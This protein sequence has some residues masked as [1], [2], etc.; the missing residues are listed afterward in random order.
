MATQ[1]VE[2]GSHPGNVGLGV[3]TG[4]MQVWSEL[5]L[6]SYGVMLAGLTILVTNLVRTLW[7][8]SRRR[9]LITSRL[10]G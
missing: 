10:S 5:W 7:R 6:V 3:I 4:W 1:M 2:T 9:K 8:A